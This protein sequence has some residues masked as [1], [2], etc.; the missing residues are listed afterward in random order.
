[1][2]NTILHNNLEIF[3]KTNHGHYN[4]ERE[5]SILNEGSSA[6]SVENL[7]IRNYSKF[8]SER[9]G[10]A[11]NS[12]PDIKL[13]ASLELS[14]VFRIKEENE[15]MAFEEDLGVYNHESKHEGVNT[16]DNDEHSIETNNCAQKQTKLKTDYG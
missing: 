8:I 12:K 6:N 13:S 1:M 15:G 9:K 4:I 10:S 5:K 16:N 3:S 2:A 14:G 11:K 7:D